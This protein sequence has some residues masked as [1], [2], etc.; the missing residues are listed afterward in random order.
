MPFKKLL[1]N[2]HL[3]QLLLPLQEKLRSQRPRNRLFLLISTPET[4]KQAKAKPVEVASTVVHSPPTPAEVAKVT[5]PVAATESSK[6]SAVAVNAV[7]VTVSAVNAISVTGSAV[8]AISVAAAAV[9]NHE[10]SLEEEGSGD[11]GSSSSGS[12]SSGEEEEQDEEEE[13]EDDANK[14]D[15]SKDDGSDDD[16]A[17]KLEEDILV[18][19]EDEDDLERKPKS[20]LVQKSVPGHFVAARKKNDF[21]NKSLL[22]CLFFFLIIG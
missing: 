9:E 2:Q 17:Y 20:K 11:E 18:G 10:E 7:S 13:E 12:G 19:G 16:E 4:V 14:D 8:N 1:N 22:I 3:W 6:D 5:S 15:A 21:L